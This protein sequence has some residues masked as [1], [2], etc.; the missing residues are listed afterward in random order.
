MQAIGSPVDFVG[1]NIYG[2]AAYV[3]AAAAGS[4]VGGSAADSY[5]RGSAASVGFAALPMP[6]KFPMMNSSWLRIAPEALYWA[7]ATWPRSGT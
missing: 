5:L 2:P 3:R 6:A 7:R 4:D 1:I